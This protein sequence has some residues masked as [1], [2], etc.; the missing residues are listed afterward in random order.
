[1]RNLK[2]HIPVQT[3]VKFIGAKRREISLPYEGLGGDMRN[4]KQHIP[5][6]TPMGFIGAEA[7]RNPIAV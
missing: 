1:M 7:E 6:Q 2:Q 4:L 5:V 3:P